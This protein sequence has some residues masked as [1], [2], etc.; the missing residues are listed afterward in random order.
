MTEK[1]KTGRIE[2]L[3][4]ETL[5]QTLTMI[6]APATI[7]SKAF[8]TAATASTLPVSAATISTDIRRGPADDVTSAITYSTSKHEPRQHNDRNGI[9]SNNSKEWRGNSSSWFL[10]VYAGWRGSTLY[11]S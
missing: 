7:V 3:Q 11:T 8:M 10:R 9:S 6:L 4:R 1:M 5:L 2:L